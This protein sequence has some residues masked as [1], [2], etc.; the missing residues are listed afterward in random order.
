M[1]KS[2]Q[3]APVLTWYKTLSLAFA[4]S[5]AVKQNE[6]VRKHLIKDNYVYHS[7]FLSFVTSVLLTELRWE[8]FR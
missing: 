3:V 2:H 5:S 7:T 1:T 6:T 8:S 4:N